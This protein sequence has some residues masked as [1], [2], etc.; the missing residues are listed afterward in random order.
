[1]IVQ[2]IKCYHYNEA[3]K[4]PFHSPQTNRLRADSVI[5]GVDCGTDGCGWGECAP[6]PYVTGEDPDS[7]IALIAGVLAPAMRSQSFQTLEDIDRLLVDLEA[8]CRTRGVDAYNAALAA[9]D[10]AVL[11][12]WEQSGVDHAKGLFPVE[13]RRKLTFSASIPLLAPEIIAQYLPIVMTHMD[14]Q[15]VKVLVGGESDDNYARVKLIRELVGPAVELRLEMNGKL[16]PERVHAELAR[17]MCFNPYA[18]EQPLPV[19]DLRNL[20][21]LRDDY[22]LAIVADESLVR[23][24]DARQ[25]IDAGAC[26]I[27]NIKI[28]K[29]GGIRKSLQIARMA[30]RAGLKCQVG[31]HVGETELLGGLVGDLLAAFLILIATA[32]GLLFFSRIF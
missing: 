11:S 3:F 27:F 5:V 20:R 18:V 8:V 13:R 19:G 23:P 21:R 30:A 4:V 29:C 17:L 10:L 16:A 1:M 2:R 7:V 14:V 22:G 26:D 6:R 28:S 12:V 32:V 31:T 25:L 15:I 24:E 9:I